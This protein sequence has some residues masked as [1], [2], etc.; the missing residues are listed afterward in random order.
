MITEL[1]VKQMAAALAAGEFSAEEAVA[2]YLQRI[3]TLDAE[4][5]AYIT[6]TA[7]QALA[8]ARASDARRARGEN[9]SPLDGVPMALKDIICTDG[10]ATT[11]ASRMLE[12]YLPPYNATCWQRLADAGAVLLGKL[13][14]DEFAMGSSTETSAFGVTRNPHD[15]E[16]VPGGS[17]GG[18]AAAVAADMAVYALGTDTGGSVRQPAHFCGVVGI[19]PTYGR[20]SRFGVVPYASSLDQVGIL[21]K[22]CWDA[23]AV[24]E[25]I[26]GQDK[27]DSTSA[28]AAVGP[29]AAACAED[30]RGL[31]I[32][33]VKEFISDAIAP[34]IRQALQAAAEKLAGLGAE[35]EEVSLPHSSYALPAY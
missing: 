22:D 12:H 14:M 18:S 15:R 3:E 32:G 10:V 11:C 25:T 5:N 31:R 28:P 21:A 23:A 1:T 7:E 27:M 2:A 34:P 26:A 30:I 9:L 29:Y 17:S 24:L 6:V 16:R 13:N 33:L 19:K 35:V 20:I 8:A 4:L